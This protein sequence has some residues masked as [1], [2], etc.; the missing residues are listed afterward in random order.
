MSRVSAFVAALALDLLGAGGALLASLPTW[1]TVVTTRA[2]PLPQDRLALSGRAVDAAP[3]ALALV[4]LAG[5][6]AVLATRGVVRRAVG[7]VLAA[8]GA[9]LVSRAAG[10]FTAVSDARARDLVSAAHRTVDAQA[11]RVS[12]AGTAVWPALSVL[13]GLCVIVAGGLVAAR[14]HRWRALSARYDK[15]PE[16]SV[17]PTRAAAAT[18]N[19]L[20]RGEDPTT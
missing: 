16:R 14:G 6:V 7:L 15:Q 18:W 8:A 20:D 1:Q 13:C 12:V 10:A 4:A 2:R 5:V 9:L 19:A 11:G 3:T 17:D